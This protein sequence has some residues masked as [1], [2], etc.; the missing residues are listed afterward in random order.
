MTQTIFEKIISR[1]I[2]AHIIYEDDLCIAFLDISPTA[3]GHT[4]VVPKQVYINI[5]DI[6]NGT[7]MHITSITKQLCEHICQ[8]LSATGAHIVHNAGTS[9]EQVVPHF[10]MHIVPRYDDDEIKFWPSQKQQH[11]LVAL[12]EVLR[13][14]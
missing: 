2:P 11:D 9:A 5:F 1:D 6:D 12:A 13:R 7:F 14:T 3:K 4:L 10:H 8:R